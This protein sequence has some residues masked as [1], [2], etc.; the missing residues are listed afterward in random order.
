MGRRTRKSRKTP[1]KKKARSL[2]L[3][4]P[5]LLLPHPRSPWKPRLPRKL[6]RR[7]SLWRAVRTAARS[8]IRVQRKK[9][10]PQL[11]QPPPEQPSDRLQQR[12]QQRALRTAPALTVL[13]T[14]L[15]PSQQVPPGICQGGQLLLQ[16]PAAAAATAPRHLRVWPGA[17]DQE[18]VAAW[19]R[20]ITVL[21]QRRGQSRLWSPP[22]SEAGPKQLALRLPSRPPGGGAGSWFWRL[23]VD[24][25]HLSES[26]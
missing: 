5:C 22:G 16:A 11:R 13:R 19:A 8:L 3:S 2:K 23:S 20:A 9:R 12:R 17:S 25:E 14:E 15:L 10:S 1:T 4:P 24:G 26:W 6:Q 7:N 21:M 18:A